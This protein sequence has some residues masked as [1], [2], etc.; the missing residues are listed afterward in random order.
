MRS[1]VLN[2]DPYF[3][4][5]DSQ[6]NPISASRILPQRRCL[7]SRGAPLLRAT[8]RP[9]R[10]GGKSLPLITRHFFPLSAFLPWPPPA[11]RPHLFSRVVTARRACPAW[12]C[13]GWGRVSAFLPQLIVY[14]Y[15][16]SSISATLRPSPDGSLHLPIPPE[17][18]CVGT[19][20]V[21]AWIEPVA[22]RAPAVGAGEWAMQ[23]RG[24]ARP[25][26]DESSE[27][28]REAYLRAKFGVQ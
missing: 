15:S 23:A 22:E 12:P 14:P 7:R 28:A 10:L 5:I 21:I 3:H 27:D 18:R 20:R 9:L 17:L 25:P 2:P 11:L 13:L 8:L 4:R 19:L 16:M 24:I 26:V 1:L 6:L